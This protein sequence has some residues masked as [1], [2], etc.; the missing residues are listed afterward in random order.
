MASHDNLTSPFILKE[1]EKEKYMMQIYHDEGRMDSSC[2]S[3]FL[4]YVFTVVFLP[5]LLSAQ[6]Y[7]CFN[8]G[9][10]DQRLDPIHIATTLILFATIALIYR[11]TIDDC[12]LKNFFV[13]RFPDFGIMVALSLLLLNNMGFIFLLVFNHFIGTFAILGNIYLL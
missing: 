3:K 12:G 10:L 1:D 9:N 13:I 2:F 4:D 7:L 8:T 5:M 6:F 11:K